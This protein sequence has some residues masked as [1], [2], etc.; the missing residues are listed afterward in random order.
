VRNSRSALRA[1]TNAGPRAPV[2]AGADDRAVAVLNLQHRQA[3]EAHRRASIVEEIRPLALDA[4]NGGETKPV[5]VQQRGFERR[6]GALA[7]EILPN[8]LDHLVDTELVL[9]REA[10]R[11]L[12]PEPDHR[13]RDGD[14]HDGRKGQEQACPQTHRVS[15]FIS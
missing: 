8:D 3:G 9:V 4:G 5:V 11:H 13:Q 6:D 12:L 10:P 1:A 7:R 2:S 14:E 15:G